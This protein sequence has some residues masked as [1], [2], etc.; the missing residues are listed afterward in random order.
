MFQRILKPLLAAIAFAAMLAP[1]HAAVAQDPLLTKANSVPPNLMLIYD[2]SG[3]M[4]LDYIYK[5]GLASSNGPKGPTSLTYAAFSP[6]I[7]LLYYNP[8]NRYLARIDWDGTPL[9][10]PL[11]L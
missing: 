10:N 7:N 4:T 6:D 9:A 2:S 5:I 3:S 1:L 11:S 8:M